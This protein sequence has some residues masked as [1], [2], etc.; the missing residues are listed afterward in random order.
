MNRFSSRRADD[1][2]KAFYNIKAD[3]AELPKP[4]LHPGTRQPLKP[5]DL[6]ALFPRGFIAH[7][8][9]TDRDIPIPREVLEALSVYRPTPLVYASGLRKALET[10]ARIFYK[11]EGVGPAG[12]HKRTTLTGSDSRRCSQRRV[13]QTTAMEGG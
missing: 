7:E 2:P 6:E 4:A 3:L 9:A 5:Q 1:L 12:S 10:P 8:T 13:L 11:Y